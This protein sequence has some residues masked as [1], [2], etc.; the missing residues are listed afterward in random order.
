[1]RIKTSTLETGRVIRL[2]AME[3]FTTIREWSIQENGRMMKCMVKAKK[4]GLMVQYS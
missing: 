2:K 3:H 4:S 1:M